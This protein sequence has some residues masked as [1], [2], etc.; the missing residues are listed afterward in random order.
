MQTVADVHL[1]GDVCS[2]D[3]N[4]FS[5]LLAT[6]AVLFKS[7]YLHIYLTTRAVFVLECE[8]TDKQRTNDSIYATISTGIIRSAI[9]YL[10]NRCYENLNNTC[11]YFSSTQLVGD[12]R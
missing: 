8:Q 1:K 11:F 2:L 3:T 9:L 4:A 6:I 10:E 12:R 5:A 7:I